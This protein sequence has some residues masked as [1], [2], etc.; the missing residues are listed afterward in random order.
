MCLN[1]LKPLQLG[2]H[3]KKMCHANSNMYK[4]VPTYY[5]RNDR[6]NISQAGQRLQSSLAPQYMRYL[7]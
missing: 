2:H 1:G 7:I 6:L 4:H 5:L 3:T